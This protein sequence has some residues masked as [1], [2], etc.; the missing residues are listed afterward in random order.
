MVKKMLTKGQ[1]CNIITTMLL[2]FVSAVSQAKKQIWKNLK[3]A[4]DK[5]KEMMYNSSCAAKVSGLWKQAKK[6]GE[7]RIGPWKLNNEERRT[8]NV[9]W[10][11]YSK[12][13]QWDV[14]KNTS[15]NSRTCQYDKFWIKRLKLWKMIWTPKGVEIQIL[16]SLILAQDER[17]RRA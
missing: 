13:L 16:E 10:V 4:L 11:E 1:S 9:L 2:K 5:R 17:W 3:K 8:R 7:K 6:Q 14:H 12:K 15:V